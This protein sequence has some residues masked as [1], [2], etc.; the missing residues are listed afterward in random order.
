LGQGEPTSLEIASDK[1]I[2]QV[3][4]ERGNEQTRGEPGKGQARREQCSRD[5]GIGLTLPNS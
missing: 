3:E 1:A 2:W 5:S 4:T